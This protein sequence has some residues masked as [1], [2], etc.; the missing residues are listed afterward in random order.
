[1]YASVTSASES[2]AAQDPAAPAPGDS[3]SPAAGALRPRYSWPQ[4]CRRWNVVASAVGACDVH[5]PSPANP[6][7]LHGHISNVSTDPRRRRRGYARACLDALL[8]WFREETPV[9]VVNLNATGD[10][11]A[12]YE[13]FGF[14]APRH[15]ALQLRTGA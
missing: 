4:R 14:A 2:S 5:A 13:S 12:L 15:P 6:S 7:G 11:A 9:T 10:G 1:M 3:T 8:T